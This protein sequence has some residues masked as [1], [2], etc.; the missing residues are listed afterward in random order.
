M[1]LPCLLLFSLGKWWLGAVRHP[2]PPP[3][4]CV[5]LLL[6]LSPGTFLMLKAVLPHMTSVHYGK[7]V[8]VGGT[9]GLKAAPGVM[10]YSASK[11]GQR[12]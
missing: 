4:L 2:H 12:G 9:F 11:F 6:F 1:V 5:L 8:V 3:P 7:I 10:A